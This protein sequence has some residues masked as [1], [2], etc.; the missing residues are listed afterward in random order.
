MKILISGCSF[1]YGLALENPE[2]CVAHII[3]T[4]TNAEVENISVSGSSNVEIFIRTQLK[5]VD[6]FYDKIYVF[7]TSVP[8]INF[9]PEL[10]NYPLSVLFT[11]RN[12]ELGTQQLSDIV[13]NEGLKIRNPKQLFNTILLLNHDWH[14]IM[15]IVKFTKILSVNPAVR[16]VNS[17][18]PWDKGFW[19]QFDKFDGIKF[20][21]DQLTRYTQKLL[22]V[23]NRDDDQINSIFQKNILGEYKRIGNIQADKWINLE[24]SWVINRIDLATDNQ[25]PGPKSHQWMAQQI[26]GSI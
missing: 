12:V 13:S 19:N 3:E 1:P 14:E 16:F 7:W 26:L 5:M 9:Y 17:I 23:S 21:P 15:D 4:T 11:P 18:C 2:D 22:N 8:R 24:N 6:N 20:I 25:H 10:D